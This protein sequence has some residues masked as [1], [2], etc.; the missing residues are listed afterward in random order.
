MVNYDDFTKKTTLRLVKL[1]DRAILLHGSIVYV[2]RLIDGA[3]NTDIYGDIIQDQATMSREETR[4]IVEFSE[5]YGIEFYEA[6]TL[7]IVNGEVAANPDARGSAIVLSDLDINQGDIIEIPFN[8]IH[9]AVSITTYEVI[10]VNVE[11]KGTI[12]NKRIE[13]TYR[14]EQDLYE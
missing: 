8:G 5:A 13:F 11:S 14:P 3:E 4:M 1:Y 2:R 10:R 6:P 12:Y 9:G 7:Q